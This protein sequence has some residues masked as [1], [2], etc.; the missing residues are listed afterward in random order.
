MPNLYDQNVPWKNPFVI[1]ALSLFR[2]SVRAGLAD[3]ALRHSI[4][5]FSCAQ[6]RLTSRSFE[7]HRSAENSDWH[8]CVEF[9]GMAGRFLSAWLAGLT[10]ARVLRPLFSGRR[11]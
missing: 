10:L 9:S 3:F 4:A 7:S 6:N 11:D 5:S 8:M 2:H 1:P